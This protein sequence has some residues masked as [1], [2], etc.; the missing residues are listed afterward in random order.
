MCY[1]NELNTIF[2][3]NAPSVNNEIW[4]SV[5][6]YWYMKLKRIVKKSL[7]NPTKPLE[8]EGYKKSCNFTENWMEKIFSYGI[9]IGN[10]YGFN[11]S[12]N[13]EFLIKKKQVLIRMKGIVLRSNDIMKINIF[14]V[15]FIYV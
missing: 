14:Y 5:K 10:C 12:Q 13:A 15:S 8:S 1:W 7:I 6:G 4:S 11:K 3:A 2:Y 9:W